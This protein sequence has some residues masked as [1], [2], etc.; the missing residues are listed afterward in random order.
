[1][2]TFHAK[3]NKLPIAKLIRNCLLAI[4]VNR[5]INNEN[6]NLYDNDSNKK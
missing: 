4:T 5:P 6:F 2:S 3:A 1:M